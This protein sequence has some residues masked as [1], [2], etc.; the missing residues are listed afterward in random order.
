MNFD[1]VGPKC[2]PDDI[3]KALHKAVDHIVQVRDYEYLCIMIVSTMR[4][5]LYDNDAVTN[6]RCSLINSEMQTVSR[7]SEIKNQDTILKHPN[8]TTSDTSNYELSLHN[9]SPSRLYP[10]PLHRSQTR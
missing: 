10:S 7:N 5:K 6:Y 8:S 1:D 4:Q 9:I 2:G 3:A